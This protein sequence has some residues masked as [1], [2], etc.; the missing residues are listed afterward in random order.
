MSIRSAFDV[1]SGREPAPSDILTPHKTVSQTSCGQ[2]TTAAKQ[3]F[4]ASRS[5]WSDP[6]SVE[7]IKVSAKDWFGTV[8]KDGF[9][10]FT[11]NQCGHGYYCCNMSRTANN[12]DCN[13]LGSCADARRTPQKRT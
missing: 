5:S 12:Y 6:W 7:L 11:H 8:R 9:V 1:L 2:N 10:Q 4:S 3:K 13:K